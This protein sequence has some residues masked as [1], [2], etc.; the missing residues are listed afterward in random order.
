MSIILYKNSLI[1]L[2]DAQCYFDERFDSDKWHELDDNVKEKLLITASRL[3]SRFDF[4][5]KAKEISQPLAFPRDYD[6]PQDIKDAVC[7]EA[8]ALIEKMNDV[9][10][11]N[12]SNHISSI[13]LGV[14]SVSYHQNNSVSK[15]ILYSP[16]ALY[17]VKKWVSKACFMSI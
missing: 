5:G 9:H 12:L 15:D 16:I 14:G 17:L 7:E 10:Q 8:Y 6:L 3:I 2:E 11:K 13:S 4:V 1:T